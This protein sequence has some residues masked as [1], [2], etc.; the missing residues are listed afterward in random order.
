MSMFIKFTASIA[1]K[2][3]NRDSF[4]R[5]QSDKGGFKLSRFITNTAEVYAEMD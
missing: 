2:K 3:R 4:C 5:S 1:Y